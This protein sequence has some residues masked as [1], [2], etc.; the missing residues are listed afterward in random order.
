LD[1]YIA[2]I[3]ERFPRVPAELLFNIDECSFNDR[4][5]RKA[6]LVLIPSKIRNTRFHHH[7]DRQIRHQTLTCCITAAGEVYCSLLISAVHFARQGFEIA[8]RHRIRLKI[9][10]ASSPGVTHDISDMSTDGVMIPAVI[11]LSVWDLTWCKN[12][13]A[14]L[15]CD[16][17]PAHCSDEVLNK[18]RFFGDSIPIGGLES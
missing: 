7:V 6:K 15:L 4:E 13:P 11:S 14:V 16:K 5:E 3:K 12:K 1:Q 17:C 10:F 9:E 2:L 18:L 8:V